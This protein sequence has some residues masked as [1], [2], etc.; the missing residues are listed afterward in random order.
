MSAPTE[1]DWNRTM[2]LV[3]SFYN[4]PEAEPFRVPVDWKAYG[5]TDYPHI[6]KHPMDLGTIKTRLK[7]KDHYQT[8]YQVNED[9]RLVWRNCMTYNADGS[10]FYTLAKDLQEKWD[11]Q[12]TAL[13]KD[14]RVAAPAPPSKEDTAGKL[15]LQDRRNF[16]KSLFQI[17]KED[18]GRVLVELEQKCP[19]ALKRNATEDEVEINV[20]NITA[21][22]VEDLNPLINNAK[23]KKAAK[24]PAKKVKA[25]PAK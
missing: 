11:K 14:C 13:L 6:I 9:V 23:K 5:L 25:A 16:A 2:K 12:Y 7:K 15:S 24:A 19:Q 20:D 22:V 18:L 21:K 8:L 10:D 4:R 1:E 3:D 17:S